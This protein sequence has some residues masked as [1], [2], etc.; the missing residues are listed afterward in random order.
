MKTIILVRHAK[1]GWDNPDM[2]DFERTLSSRGMSDAPNMAKFISLKIS[3]PDKVISSSA[4]RAFTTAKFFAKEMD[5]L[6][7]SIIQDI[8]IYERG[9]KHIF[10]LI[11]ELDENV[12]SVIVFGHNPDITSLSTYLS[13]EYFESVPTCSV[14][15]IDFEIETWTDIHNENGKVRF[16]EYPKK[17][18]ETYLNKLD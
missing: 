12:S 6:E 16:Y 11:A 10:K 2:T 1:S 5:Y 4:V 18:L 17:S 7:E 13:G 14:I 9:T 3:P 15:C 8:G